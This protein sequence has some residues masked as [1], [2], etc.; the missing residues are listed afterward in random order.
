MTIALWVSV[1]VALSVLLGT[2]L[3][4]F[5]SHRNAER[6]RSAEREEAEKLRIA[7]EK[8]QEQKIKEWMDSV[9]ARDK[10]ATNSTEQQFRQDFINLIDKHQTIMAANQVLML[11]NVEFAKTLTHREVTIDQQG[12]RIDE[13]GKRITLLEKIV[14][15]LE[16]TIEERD[17]TIELREVKIVELGK[18]VVTL[19][20]KIELLEIENRAVRDVNAEAEGA[21][22][23]RKRQERDV[24][25]AK[26]AP[27]K[28]PSSKA[29]L[30][31]GENPKTEI[32]LSGAE[33]SISSAEV[34]ISAS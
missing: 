18:Q 33:V 16:R 3:S 27:S 17:K 20:A 24:A 25:S 12:K 22:A 31:K 23:E 14:P 5:V 19:T 29:S 21:R 1:G 32:V 11:Q 30:S 8:A 15:G 6:A 2:I 9:D 28:P 10:A 7:T 4:L 34:S 26:S 13:Q